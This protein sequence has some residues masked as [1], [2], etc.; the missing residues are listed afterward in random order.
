[1]YIPPHRRARKNGF[2]QRLVRE[3]RNLGRGESDFY[4]VKSIEK[5]NEI[6][7][8][9]FSSDMDFE[10]HGICI[11]PKEWPSEPPR[12]FLTSNLPHASVVR[13]TFANVVSSS[14]PYEV[15]MKSE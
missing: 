5:E 7:V 14:L 4:R 8:D 1:M 15:C 12:I 9:F 13:G 11:L 10:V 3:I 2:K 6:H